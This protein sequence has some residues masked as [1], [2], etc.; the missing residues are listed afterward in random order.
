VPLGLPGYYRTILAIAGLVAFFGTMA[1]G[2]IKKG[3]GWLL[4]GPFYS[5]VAVLC[6]DEFILQVF[7]PKLAPYAE[8]NTWLKLT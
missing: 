8:G 6:V 5:F 3:P 1:V 7:P 4:I 2:Y